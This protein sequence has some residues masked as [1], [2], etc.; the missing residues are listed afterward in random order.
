MDALTYL[1]RMNYRGSTQPTSETLRKIHRAHLLAVPFENLDLHLN[2]RIVLYEAALYEKIVVN[3]RG[4]FCYELNGLFAALLKELGF[5]VT[6]LNSL[7]P[8]SH[9]GCG[10][11]YDHPILLVE[12]D[13]RWIVDVGFA[14]SNR[15]PLKLDD[16][17]EQMGVGVAYRI[18]PDGDGRWAF[19]KRLETGEWEF[20][21][22]FTLQPCRLS[23][24]KEACVHYETSPVSS[25]T[26]KRV[27]TIATPNGHITLTDD[28]LIIARDGHKQETPLSGEFDFTIALNEYF[29]INL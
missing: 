2:R 10:M 17:G 21:Y 11:D 9:N 5:R 13:D 14:D 20:Y 1:E 12:L 23:D 25:F 29:G 6:L 27:C 26:Q 18:T 24:F 28:R 8:E 7:I 3:K 19:H 15:L 4:G 22:A 16:R